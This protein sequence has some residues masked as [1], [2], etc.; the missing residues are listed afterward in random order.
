MMNFFNVMIKNIVDFKHN[1]K[2]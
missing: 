2:V 1:M